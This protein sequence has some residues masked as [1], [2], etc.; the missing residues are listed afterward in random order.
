MKGVKMILIGEI[1]LTVTVCVRMSQ[2]GKKWGY[3][4]LPLSLGLIIGFLLGL[5][6]MVTISTNMIWMDIII[7]II[8]VVMLISNKPLPAPIESVENEEETPSQE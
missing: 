8:L 2:A 1:I 3:G 4:L 6:G 7:I 5:S